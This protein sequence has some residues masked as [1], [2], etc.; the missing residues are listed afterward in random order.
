MT[1]PNIA[2]NV[3]PLNPFNSTDKASQSISPLRASHNSSD[4]AC[5]SNQSILSKSSEKH[6]IKSVCHVADN[7][8]KDPLILDATTLGEVFHRVYNSFSTAR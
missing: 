5:N 2:S 7:S 8:S 1:I 6:K 4:I 3:A